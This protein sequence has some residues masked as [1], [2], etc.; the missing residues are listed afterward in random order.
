MY[1]E[2]LPEAKESAAIVAAIAI[3]RAPFI[4]D[5]FFA[6]R[7]TASGFGVGL[8]RE[9]TRTRVTPLSS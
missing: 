5:S 7:A 6:R 4:R 3:R 9:T 2:A 8:R 1:V